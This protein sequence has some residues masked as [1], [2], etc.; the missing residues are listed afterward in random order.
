MRELNVVN[1][2]Y[3]RRWAQAEMLDGAWEFFTVTLRE[4]LPAFMFFHGGGWVLGD[5]PTHARLIRDL[6]V[7]SGTVA[8]SNERGALRPQLLVT[9]TVAQGTCR[10]APRAM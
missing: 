9:V 8:V 3:L 2:A 6:V 7:A 1:C 10:R 4:T 5:C